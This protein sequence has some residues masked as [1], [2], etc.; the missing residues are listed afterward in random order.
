[1]RT[2]QRTFPSDPERPTV[3][4]S[5]EDGMSAVNEH[6][7]PMYLPEENRQVARERARRQVCGY[8]DELLEAD[9]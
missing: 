6:S 1:M 5:W 9:E 3:A 4:V 8:D 7:S 2:R